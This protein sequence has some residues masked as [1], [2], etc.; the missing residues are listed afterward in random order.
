MLIRILLSL[1]FLGNLSAEKKISQFP[2]EASIPHL[3]RTAPFGLITIPKS[4]THL[5]MKCLEL[6]Q[7][8]K[9]SL[10]EI[11]LNYTDITIM[12]TKAIFIN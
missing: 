8:R 6:I 2:Q 12:N 4:G 9:I 1:L 10:L 11:L 3:P 5:I 7:S